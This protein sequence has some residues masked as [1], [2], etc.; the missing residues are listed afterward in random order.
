MN[1]IFNWLDRVL[2]PSYQ[3]TEKD[4]EILYYLR[5]TQRLIMEEEN[6][7]KK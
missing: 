2:S 5:L 3:P 4:Y 7:N 6:E 1:Q